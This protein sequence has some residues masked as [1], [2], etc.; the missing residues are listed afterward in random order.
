MEKKINKLVKRIEELKFKNE[1]LLMLIDKSQVVRNRA[2]NNLAPTWLQF[3]Y[4]DF[5]VATVVHVGDVI[6]RSDSEM[7]W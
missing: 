6:V 1:I 5:D 3:S 2:L 7:E 4:V